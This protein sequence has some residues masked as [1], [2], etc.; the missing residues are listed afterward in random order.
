[1]KRPP[2][3]QLRIGTRGAMI[4]ILWLSIGFGLYAEDSYYFHIFLRIGRFGI[5][6][7][8]GEFKD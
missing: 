4:R 8:T 6:I 1:M 5:D 2:L 7:K 3:F